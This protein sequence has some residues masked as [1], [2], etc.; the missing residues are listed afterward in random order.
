MPSPFLGMDPYLERPDR[1]SGVHARLIAVIG[2]MLARQV[3]PRFFVDSG[4]ARVS[5]RTGAGAGVDQPLAGDRPPAR[6]DS[7]ARRPR[8]CRLDP[9]APC[10][11][12]PGE[13]GRPAYGVGYHSNLTLLGGV[14]AVSYGLPGSGRKDVMTAC[15]HGICLDS[16]LRG[17]L[18]WMTQV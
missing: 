15:S 3:A 16:R 4:A 9:R 12:A 13:L 17:A 1:W 2:E 7:P 5:P 8:R 6:W 10:W 18:P 14:A 11:L